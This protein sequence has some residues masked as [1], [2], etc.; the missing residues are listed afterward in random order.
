MK[1]K[2]HH[3]LIIFCLFL[4]ILSVCAKNITKEEWLKKSITKIKFQIDKNEFN[5]KHGL[6]GQNNYLI[7]LDDGDWGT[8]D[9][10]LRIR[11]NTAKDKI[12][13]A[14]WKALNEDL[15]KL[16]SSGIESYLIVI[17]YLPFTIDNPDL[18]KETVQS[19]FSSASPDNTQQSALDA[20]KDFNSI[21]SRLVGETINGQMGKKYFC[22]LANYYAAKFKNQTNR[23]FSV[24]SNQKT[25]ALKDDFINSV[26]GIIKNSSLY[27]LNWSGTNTGRAQN[28]IKVISKAVC[29][30]PEKNTDYSC[31]GSGVLADD[32][33]GLVV[34]Y[35]QGK[36]G[37]SLLSKNERQGIEDHV[38]DINK[39]LTVSGKIYV[40]NP[41]NPNYKQL[42]IKAQN[43][44]TPGKTI[45]TLTK[46]SDGKIVSKMEYS[47]T[48]PQ[49][50]R[51][52]LPNA[53]PMTCAA[54]YI[55]TALETLHNSPLYIAS[56][57]DK[58]ILAEYSVVI[59]RGIFGTLYCSTGEDALKNAGDVSK[60]FGG[61]LHELIATVDVAEMVSGLISLGKGAVISTIDSYTS[62]IRDIK[63]TIDD[64]KNNT[65]IANEELIRRMMPPNVRQSTALIKTA[66]NIGDKFVKFYFTDCKDMCPY[67]YGQVT[68]IIVPIVLTAGNWAVVKGGAL[69]AR[70]K[71]LSNLGKTLR[72]TEEVVKLMA[73]AEKV[74]VSIVNDGEKIL[75]KESA[76]ASSDVITTIEKNG[77]EV[78]IEGEQ[79][80]T[81]VIEEG[82]LVENSP[83]SNIGPNGEII[84]HPGSK[85]AW[86]K[87]LN[88]TPLEAN[89][90]YQ[91]GNYKYYTDAQGRV[92]KVTLENLV[93]NNRDRNLYQQSVKCKKA[94]NGLAGDDGGHIGASQYDGA[95]EQIN[96]LP[97][98]ASINRAGGTYYRM[99]TEW[100]SVLNNNG[101]VT[102][103]EWDIIYG[104]DGRPTEIKVTCDVNQR[105]K[106]YTHIN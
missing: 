44:A 60:Y 95:G 87:N 35:S 45:V 3:L 56:A 92:N 100:K 99:E 17:N 7:L 12:L 14:D 32:G 72:K 4:N 81:A 96:N 11:K 78:I 69:V 24:Y 101:T 23:R 76:D 54:D 38:A 106:I 55:N 61:A 68:V 64:I 46:G 16:S 22:G 39:K 49:W 31:V 48:A 52:L 15:K 86:N 104:L 9:D 91:V 70:L 50:I 10:N 103:I 73:D 65:P 28:F 5:K 40:L 80:L 30:Y 26:Q 90:I 41:D 47:F 29:D 8:I 82:D 57:I 34:D 2:Y 62:Y 89:K 67:R 85:G 105:T 27:N 102:N 79:N 25:A 43:D 63:Q 6:T 51:D 58:K 59:Y 75:V 20:R 53:G 33:S 77:D 71:T 83:I 74:G 93:L 19:L 36:D 13:E 88:Q 21:F 18:D 1:K 84:E 97:M 37:I 42:L 66:V 94:K 98:K